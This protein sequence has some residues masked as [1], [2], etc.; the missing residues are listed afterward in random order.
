MTSTGPIPN[1]V[2]EAEILDIP[3]L[4]RDN[5]HARAVLDG[6]I[7]QEMLGKFDTKGF[8]ALAWGE[9]GFRHM[10]NSKRAVNGA[11]GPEG[12]EDAH[13]GEPDPHPGLQGLRH[14]PD[15]DGV[16][17]GVHGSAAGYGRR[18]GKSDLRY[19][20]GQVR[21]GAKA[22]DPNRPRVFAGGDPDEQGPWTSSA[23][24][25]RRR[26]SRQPRWASKPIARASTDDEKR[27]RLSRSKGMQWSRMS[28]R[29]N[30]EQLKPVFA[31]FRR[32][33][34]R[35][36]SSASGTSSDSRLSGAAATRN[37]HGERD[38]R[39]VGHRSEFWHRAAHHRLCH[40][41]RLRHAGDRRAVGPVSDH[42][43]LH[44]RAA[45]GM[46]RGIVRFALI[47]MVF[48]GIPMAFRQGA[49]V[50]VDLLYRSSALDSP[51]AR[52]VYFWP[53]LI[54][55]VVDHLVRLR[56]CVANA[57]PDHP[58]SS[59]SRCSGPTRHAGW[60]GVLRPRH[61]RQWLDPRRHELETAQ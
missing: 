16:Q 17:R 14:H 35:P 57:L 1:F 9:N 28:T 23:K 44:H 4:F 47:W 32:S 31:E 40:G 5:A 3:F 60:R 53:R 13:D 6:P 24:R 27:R 42:H 2:P 15:A 48:L 59:R 20:R 22:P 26:F 34:A 55:M 52:G 37:S 36:T 21:P 51:C 12:P 49:M 50:C 56:L 7:G 30:S 45:G 18:P 61:L 39:C 46:D 58:A 8:K 38:L 41:C 43:T 11:G 54:L 33:S 19:H 29:P 10:T 25:T